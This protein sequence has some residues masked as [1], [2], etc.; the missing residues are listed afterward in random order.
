MQDFLQPCLVRFRIAQQQVL[1]NGSAEQGIPLRDINQVAAGPGR[2]FHFFQLIVVEFQQ[3]A[4]GAQQR[5]HQTD[6]RALPHTRFSHDGRAAAGS[7]IER[8]IAENILF[9]IRIPERKVL[10][11]DAAASF[12]HDWLPLVFLRCA[13]QFGQPVDRSGRIDKGGNLVRHPQQRALNLADELQEGR[14][15]TEGYR[16]V[17]NAVNTPEEGGDVTQVKGCPDH[18]PRENVETRP[19]QDLSE[20]RFLQVIQPL[21]HHLARFQRADDVAVLQTLLD[22]ALDAA[23]AIP[24]VF[25]NAMHPAE[26]E[27]AKGQECRRNQHQ[28]QGQP[29]FQQT[30]ESKGRHELDEG[31]DH[32]RELGADHLRHLVHIAHQPVQGIARVEPF[33]SR[34]LGAQQVGIDPFAD[35]EVHFGRGDV[36]QAEVERG[37]DQ[38][39]ADD[40]KNRGGVPADRARTDLRGDIHQRF[41]HPD[42]DQVQHHRGHTQQ[43]VAQERTPRPFAIAIQPPA[44]LKQSLHDSLLNKSQFHPFFQEGRGILQGRFP[45]HFVFPGQEIRHGLGRKIHSLKGLPQKGSRGIQAHKFAEIH[46]FQAFSG[47]YVLSADDPHHKTFFDSH[48]AICLYCSLNQPFQG[49]RR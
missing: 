45:V 37:T 40:H 25:G 20:F 41:A 33:L 12:Q 30:E 26:K 19:V 47:D 48:F 13:F 46:L 8:K 3:T 16:A 32:R 23:L 29:P 11:A 7:E 42:K 36:F 22:M 6:Q 44:I 2:D 38:P 35:Q 17:Q 34:P 9:S 31:R 27:L 21:P 43:D 10:H 28:Q 4:R 5:Q 14:H 15:Q 49:S 24:D 1:A 18:R 39:E